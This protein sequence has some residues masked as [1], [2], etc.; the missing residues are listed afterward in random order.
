MLTFLNIKKIDSRYLFFL[1]QS[2]KKIDY[3]NP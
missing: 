3:L 1:M 2:I